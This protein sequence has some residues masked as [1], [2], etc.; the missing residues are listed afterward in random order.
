MVDIVVEKAIE[1]DNSKLANVHI[2]FYSLPHAAVI[3]LYTPVAILQGIYAKYYG[4]P[5][6]TIA[7]VILFARFFDAITDPLIG[8]YADRCQRRFGTRKPFMIAGGVLFIFA[9]GFL[10][11][12]P[13]DVTVAY[14]S[15]WFILFYLGW[16]LFEIPHL[17]WGGNIAKGT[18]DKTKIYSGRA[19]AGYL[20]MLLFYSIP[21]LPFFPT[22]HITPETLRW[23]AI[24]SGALML[25]TLYL[26]IKKVPDVNGGDR[27]GKSTAKKIAGKKEL[28]ESF[29][30]N[31]PFLN[32]LA[33]IIFAGLGIGMWYGLIFIYVDSYLGMGDQFAEIFLYSFIV[34]LLTT[35]LWFKLAMFIGKK[36]AWFLTISLL[37][38]SS[39]Y[40]G[41]LEP[42]TV[43]FSQLIT[44]KMIN[45]LGFVGFNI[46]LPSLLSDIVDFSKWKS[47]ADFSAS[48]FAVE[49]FIYKFIYAIGAALGLAISGWYGFQASSLVQSSEGVFGIH[50]AIVVLPT[51]CF[52]ICLLLSL[53][54]PINAHRHNI[55]RRRLDAR[56]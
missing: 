51:V 7:A 47:K 9:G 43:V 38:V 18:D 28:I 20:G 29:I 17:A 55:I 13:E 32:F 2:W 56:H 50:I 6:S 21:L 31:K 15:F 26:C 48:Y 45:T 33:V 5:L 19:A 46:L 12:P 16:T 4:I 25:P 42:N 10:Y 36:A 37:L 24:V 54:M 41:F 53:F 30:H 44:L 1:Q 23:C 8:Y 22:N 39:I 35:P 14:F 40:T 3:L 11:I 27:S 34:G 49:T 52:L